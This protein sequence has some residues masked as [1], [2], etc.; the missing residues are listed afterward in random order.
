LTR[1]IGLPIILVMDIQILISEILASGLTQTEVAKA[2]MCSQATVS[3]IARGL[4][5]TTTL[6][7]GL[8]IL[9][10]HKK[11]AKKKAA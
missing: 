3:D 11:V 6:N 4:Q 2:I 7:L 5:K 9:A 8:R 1:S 10:L